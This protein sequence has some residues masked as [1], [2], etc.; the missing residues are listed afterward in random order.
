[1]HTVMANLRVHL[2]KKLGLIPEY[3]RGGK[4]NFL[5]VVNPPLFEY[6]EET[7]DAG[8]RRTTRSRARTTRTCRTSRPI[9]AG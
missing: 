5:W 6:D 2:A 1:M 3:G 7:Q 8:P 4:W 9:R